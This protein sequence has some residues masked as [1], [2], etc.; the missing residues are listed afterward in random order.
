[1]DSYTNSVHKQKICN[2]YAEIESLHWITTLEISTKHF[3]RHSGIP[4]PNADIIEIGVISKCR[5]VVID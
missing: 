3:D 1:M 4:I 2:C 5:R